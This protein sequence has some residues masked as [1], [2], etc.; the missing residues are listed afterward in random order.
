MPQKESKLEAIYAYSSIWHIH[1]NVDDCISS[2]WLSVCYMLIIQDCG[3]LFFFVPC[4]HFVHFMCMSPTRQRNLSFIS[5]SRHASRGKNCANYLNY[6][7]KLKVSATFNQTVRVSEHEMIRISKPATNYMAY[8]TNCHSIITLA[9]FVSFCKTNMLLR[10]I[11]VYADVW[12]S[13]V[14]EQRKKAQTHT[15]PHTRHTSM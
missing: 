2:D 7:Q 3:L 15:Q 10:F 5:F 8:S 11:R 6:T 14:R 1:L 13:F 9:R 4:E 12:H